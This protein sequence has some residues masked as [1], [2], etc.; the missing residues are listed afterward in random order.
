MSKD[1]QRIA[2][3][4]LYLQQHVT[5]QPKLDAVASAIGL[6]AAHFQRLFKRW[7]GVS[8]KRYLQYLTVEY[9]KQILINTNQ[10][11]TTL[12]SGLSS[13][14][15]SHEHYIKVTAMTP[16]QY[17]SAGKGLVLNYG[18]ADSPFGI[19]ALAK[20]EYGIC[21][22]QFLDQR[23]ESAFYALLQKQWSKA[24][25]KR[26][27]Q[28][29]SQLVQRLFNQDKKSEI[30]LV[31]MGS[32]FQIQ[33]WQAL[34]NI[35]LG[36]LS[37]YKRIAEAIGRPTASRAVAQAISRNPIGYLIPCHR[38]LRGDGGLGGYRWGTVRKQAIIAHEAISSQV[39]GTDYSW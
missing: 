13:T 26:D 7:A 25:L 30:Q 18:F 38:V 15:R 3:A 23:D 10:L 2:Q 9:S 27:D 19:V 4:I 28:S 39:T 20:T 12:R 33:V 14:S 16:A 32:N 31:P 6:S 5:V 1:Y 29:I 8:P 17:R 37:T 22:L 35:P 21:L 34:L 24:E 11:D 36:Q